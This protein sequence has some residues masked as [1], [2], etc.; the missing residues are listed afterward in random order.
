MDG[1][2]LFNSSTYQFWPIFGTIFE[3]P[4][5]KPFVIAIWSDE[6]KPLVNEFLKEFV[7]ELKLIM[8]NGVKI[9]N[10]MIQVEIKVFIL[11]TPARAFIKG[12]YCHL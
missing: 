3:F 1:L 9:K 8:R 11:D 12:V 6:G 7:E 5:I 4:Q 2:P 10:F